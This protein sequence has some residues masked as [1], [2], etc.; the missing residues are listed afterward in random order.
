L[1]SQE[2]IGAVESAKCY[3]AGGG[4]VPVE[5]GAGSGWEF[6]VFTNNCEANIAVTPP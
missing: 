1:A 5:S 6:R 4:E 3:C 2:G